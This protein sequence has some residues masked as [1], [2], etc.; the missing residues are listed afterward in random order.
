MF[1]LFTYSKTF[2][3]ADYER[4]DPE[5][6]FLH[7]LNAHLAGKAS[8]AVAHPHRFWEYA[9]ALRCCLRRGA[10]TVLDVGGGGSLFS[11]AAARCGLEVTQIDPG[12]FGPLV[13]SQAAAV[14]RPIHY[15]RSGLLEWRRGMYD[16]VA[17]LSVVEHVPDDQESHFLKAL[18]DHVWVGGVLVLTTDF[19]PSGRP[20]VEG[21]LR[22]YNAE[23]M[24]A[25]AGALAPRAR[26][27]P[28]SPIWS[29]FGKHVYVYNFASLVVRRIS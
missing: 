5:L 14:L 12:D 17:C 22:T 6:G 4:L 24:E 23:G 28:L 13:A 25:L 15:E 29:Y 20:L 10:D 19:H 16:V 8:P 1:D 27:W 18:L 9:L 2:R 26:S 21:H 11:P 7:G 3:P